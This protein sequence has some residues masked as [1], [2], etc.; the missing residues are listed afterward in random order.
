MRG[1]IVEIVEFH[2]TVSPKERRE[3]RIESILRFD[4]FEN[5]ETRVTI[6]RK[7]PYMT[8]TIQ[9]M[10][11]WATAEMKLCPEEFDGQKYVS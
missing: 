7:S 8:P 11:F 5:G 2:N 3:G 10:E 1:P 9:E 6:T 4:K